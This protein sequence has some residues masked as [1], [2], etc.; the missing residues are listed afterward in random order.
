MVIGFRG[1]HSEKNSVLNT[2]LLSNSIYV[3]VLVKFVVTFSR[4]GTYHYCCCMLDCR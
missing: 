3:H 2:K 1:W 4:S